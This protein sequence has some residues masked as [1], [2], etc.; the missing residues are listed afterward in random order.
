MRLTEK[1]SPSRVFYFL[2]NVGGFVV[3]GESTQIVVIQQLT[4]AGAPTQVV[5]AEELSS[6][7]SFLHLRHTILLSNVK[8]QFVNASFTCF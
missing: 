7:C 2:D 1:R 6:S 3:D 8:K 5:A 4:L